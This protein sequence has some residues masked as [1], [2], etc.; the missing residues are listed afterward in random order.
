MDDKILSQLAT[1]HDLERFATKEELDG[2]KNENFNR[3]D[4]VLL[5]LKRL[6]RERI[7]MTETSHLKDMLKIS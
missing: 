1:K 4:E 2:L 7:F 6:D 3:L 5:I